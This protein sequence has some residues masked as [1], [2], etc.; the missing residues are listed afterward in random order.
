MA[1]NNNNPPYVHLFSIELHMVLLLHACLASY[2][3]TAPF[4]L[5]FGH[6]HSY[7]FSILMILLH[8]AYIGSNG[9]SY[10]PGSGD[11]DWGCGQILVTTKDGTLVERSFSSWYTLDHGFSDSEGAQLLVQIS[12][13]GN[14]PKT[15]KK[16]TETLEGIPL[17]IAA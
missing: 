2:I 12:G 14:K 10:L 5:Q 8:N 4:F 7:T 13:I 16:L 11:V 1:C 3:Y 17:A 9:V 6:C 15:A